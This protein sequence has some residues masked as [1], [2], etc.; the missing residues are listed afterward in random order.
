MPKGSVTKKQEVG[1][2]GEAMACRFLQK[3]G[4]ALVTRNYWRKWGEIDI[5]A[6][7]DGVLHFIEVKSVS[8]HVSAFPQ[9]S[10]GE[11]EFEPEDQMTVSKRKKFLRIIETYLLEERVGEE[12]DYQ[13][14]VAAVYLDL[15]NKKARVRFLE[16]IEL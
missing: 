16:D 10:D 9:S 3:Q 8:R 6:K 11:G 14:D 15:E 7:K 12:I 13:A 2:V 1:R 4:F 5:V